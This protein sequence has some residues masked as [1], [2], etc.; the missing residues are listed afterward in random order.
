MSTIRID[1]S[2]EIRAL[3]ER[4][5]WNQG[6]TA[7]FLGVDRTQVSRWEGGQRCGVPFVSQLVALGLRLSTEDA[8]ASLDTPGKPAERL[9]VVSEFTPDVEPAS[10]PA[11]APPLPW[12]PAATKRTVSD[13]D[14][15]RAQATVAALAA[16]R[17]SLPTTWTSEDGITVRIP[18][19]VQGTES[20]WMPYVMGKAAYM[21]SIGVTNENDIS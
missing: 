11:A 18:E 15:A 12:T 13:D 21:R 8:N 20:L 6:V 9:A 14:Y 19:H 17:A 7:A 1:L 3:R 5:G 2:N 4:H 16:R 10:T